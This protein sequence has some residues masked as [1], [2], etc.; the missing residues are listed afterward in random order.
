MKKYVAYAFSFLLFLESLILFSCSG[1]AGSFNQDVHEYFDVMTN[2]AAI[3]KH[4]IHADTHTGNGGQLCVSSADGPIAVSYY[5]RNPKLFTFTDNVSLVYLNESGSSSASE[6]SVLQDFSDP[7]VITLVY[8]ITYLRDMEGGFTPI[9]ESINIKHPYSLEDF[10][11]YS[12]PLYC[13][14]NPP[15]MQGGVC[16]ADSNNKA[17]LFL[18]LPNE[19][20][21]RY[22]HKDLAYI[23]INGVTFGIN[24]YDNPG[25]VDFT[26]TDLKISISSSD[27]DQTNGSVTYGSNTYSRFGGSNAVYA[28]GPSGTTL[29][30]QTGDSLSE[31]SSYTVEL[32]DNFGFTSAIV[33][34][35]SATQI[36]EV[37]YE[38]TSGIGVKYTE[39][40]GTTVHNTLEEIYGDD[41]VANLVLVPPAD[42][43]D[44]VISYR[45]YKHTDAGDEFIVSG[46]VNGKNAVSI[47]CPVTAGTSETYIVKAYAHKNLYADSAESSCTV[48][49][50]ASTYY[51]QG[52]LTFTDDIMVWVDNAKVSSYTGTTALS[53]QK[54]S[55]SISLA[56]TPAS[57]NDCSN[58]IATG[59]EWS[60][61]LFLAGNPSSAVSQNSG[62]G[63]SISFTTTDAC[64][65]D[66]TYHLRIVA[67]Y[68]GRENVFDCNV[69]FTD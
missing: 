34:G 5:L 15:L 66:V 47:P 39:S 33:I 31:G 50:K 22:I 42:A 21:L 36:G 69:K 23:R 7:S 11:T 45:V 16:L 59:I 24:S 20:V 68:Q 65:T 55:V 62:T 2:T 18:N 29:L 63:N 19:D 8:P 27:V 13:N 1:L 4:E 64:V 40:D 25:T 58:P 46:T 14:S 51:S 53:K 49:T 30:Y 9:T 61:Q 54:G 10:G 57:A 3:E 28:P 52:G 32:I 37:S 67:T 41:G 17:A 38:N 60:W 56:A 48:R 43:P 44:A 12:F 6:I 35:A 26:G